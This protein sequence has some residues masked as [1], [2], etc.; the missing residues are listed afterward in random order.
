MEKWTK[1]RAMKE[2]QELAENRLKRLIDDTGLYPGDPAY[3]D[4]CK[5][6]WKSHNKDMEKFKRLLDNVEFGT[7]EEK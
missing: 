7:S 1:Q 3:V 6:H 4:L 2:M 5:K